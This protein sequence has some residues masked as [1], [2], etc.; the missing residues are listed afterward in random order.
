MIGPVQSARN[1]P[2]ALQGG[3]DEQFGEQADS[4]AALLAAQ[5]HEPWR[6]QLKPGSLTRSSRGQR[7]R[8]SHNRNVQSR[9]Q[10]GHREVPFHGSNSS[11]HFLLVANMRVQDLS[12]ISQ[13]ADS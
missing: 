13:S 10:I 9:R 2:L 11:R 8:R 4:L 3:I 5:R 7:R 1:D 12:G 6:K